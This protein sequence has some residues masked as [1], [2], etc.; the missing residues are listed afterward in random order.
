MQP[1]WYYAGNPVDLDDTNWRITPV[2]TNAKDSLNPEALHS[3][4]WPSSFRLPLH[5]M[6]SDLPPVAG[7]LGPRTRRGA[8]PRPSTPSLRSE[9]PHTSRRR[10]GRRD[11]RG[12][13]RAQRAKG[14]RPYCA[15]IALAS[16]RNKGRRDTRGAR[17]CCGVPRRVVAR[18]ASALSSPP[19]QPDGPAVLPRTQSRRRPRGP[20]RRQEIPGVLGLLP[21]AGSRQGPRP[22]RGATAA[23]AAVHTISAGSAVSCRDRRRVS[24]RNAGK[25]A[26]STRDGPRGARSSRSPASST[27]SIRPASSSALRS[28]CAVR[29]PRRRQ[30]PL[31]GLPRRRAEVPRRR[32]DASASASHGP[33]GANGRRLFAA[34]RQPHG[35]HTALGRRHTAASAALTRRVRPLV[36][37][38]HTAARERGPVPFPPNAALAPSGARVNISGYIGK[39]RVSRRAPAQWPRWPASAAQRPHRAA[40]LRPETTPRRLYSRRRG[41]QSWRP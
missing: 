24:G 22:G 12:A 5:P 30:P 27:A 39:G 10:A 14:S 25:A 15:S 21:D 13:L 2:D 37:R 31:R 11:T 32:V 33:R 23:L 1:M 8:A 9:L 17:G 7:G 35:R 36:C 6:L 40:A 20:P 19:P 29:V 38:R 28:G 41:R 18:F 3:A 34:T 26:G 4:L 16:P